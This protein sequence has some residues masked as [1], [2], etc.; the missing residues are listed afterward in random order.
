MSRS[1]HRTWALGLIAATTAAGLLVSACS[2]DS[3]TPTC[4][5][6]PLY[7]VKDASPADKQARTAAA[8]AGCV[9]GPGTATTGTATPNDSGAGG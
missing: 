3:T 4:P 8:N 1:S 7:D 5:D 2:D 9:T 6:L